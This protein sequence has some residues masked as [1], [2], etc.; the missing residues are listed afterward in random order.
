MARN[1]DSSGSKSI[2]RNLMLDYRQ[3]QTRLK[4][5][6]LQLRVDSTNSGKAESMAAIAFYREESY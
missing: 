4:I 3:G 6:E 1:E 2:G 5:C